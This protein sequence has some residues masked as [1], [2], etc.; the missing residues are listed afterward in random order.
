MTTFSVGGTSAGVFSW[1]ATWNDQTRDLVIDASGIGR[2]NVTVAQSNGQMRTV[3][4]VQNAGDT[5][6]PVP[7]GIPAPAVTIVVSDP[8]TTIPNI[9]L[10]P[11]AG[12]RSGNGGFEVVNEQWS[13]V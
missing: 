2:C 3:A 8:P 7:A 11:D 1:S 12:S 4:F 5:P 10:K 13:R 9:T 6:L